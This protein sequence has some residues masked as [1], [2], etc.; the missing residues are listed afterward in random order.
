M[1]VIQIVAI[2]LL[3]YD[4]REFFPLWLAIVIVL[5]IIISLLIG[6]RSKRSGG[7]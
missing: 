1:M 6:W 3:I 7:A 5:M 4:F 2:G